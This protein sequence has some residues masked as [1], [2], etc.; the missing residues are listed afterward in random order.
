MIGGPELR[1]ERLILRPPSLDDFPRFAETLAHPSSRYV[2]G[3]APELHAWRAFAAMAGA[4]ALTGVA[5][6]SAIERATGLWVGRVGPWTPPGWPGTEIGWTLHPDARGRG[7]GVEAARAAMDHA[8]DA[9]GWTDVIHVIDPENHASAALAARLGSTRRG[10]I[11]LPAP[12][13]DD[14]VDAWGQTAEQWRAR[15]R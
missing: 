12:Y 6:F 4:W 7:F 14:V 5:M 10:R 11:A 8:V 13:E 15:R 9:L 3:P 1:T 2:G